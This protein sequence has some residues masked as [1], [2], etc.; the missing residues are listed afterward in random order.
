MEPKTLTK[1]MLIEM[2]EEV[3]QEYACH[4]P[5]DGRWT[6]CKKGTIYSVLDTNDRVSDRFKGRGT[7]SKKKADGTYSLA[8]RFGENGKDPKKASGRKTFSGEDIPP[9]HYVGKRYPKKYEE[10]VLREQWTALQQWLSKQDSNK[11][12]IVEEDDCSGKYSEGYKQGQKN[13]LAWISA[14]HQAIEKKG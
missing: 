3:M 7:V 6:K 1:E 9:K 2:I 13:M 5:S 11:D 12:T 14:Y 10:A 4:R 8:S